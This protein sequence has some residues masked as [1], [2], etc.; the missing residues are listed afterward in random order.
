MVHMT[1]CITERGSVPKN[2]AC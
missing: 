2:Q 1:C